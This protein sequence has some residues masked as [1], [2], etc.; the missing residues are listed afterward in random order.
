M[1]AS[2]A[3]GPRL[4][5]GRLLTTIDSPA[6]ATLTAGHVVRPR[7]GNPDREEGVTMQRFELL[8]QKHI[9]QACRPQF[10]NLPADQLRAY[11]GRKGLA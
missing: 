1:P 4:R 8:N 11:F 10:W 6:L 2:S 9:Q 3:A 7:L 5:L